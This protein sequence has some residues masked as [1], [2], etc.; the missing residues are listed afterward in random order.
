MKIKIEE[1][2]RPQTVV[3]IPISSEASTSSTAALVDNRLTFLR[4]PSVESRDHLRSISGRSLISWHL[5][6]LNSS[7]C[8]LGRWTI[9]QILSVSNL[10]LSRVCQFE[11]SPRRL[12]TRP[13][14]GAF[15]LNLWSEKVRILLGTKALSDLCDGLQPLRWPLG[16]VVETFIVLM[17]LNGVK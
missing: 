1:S 4:C 6:Q 15:D 2:T 16:E 3:V 13:T 11:R 14:E 7:R 17:A 5:S 9:N 10:R 8:S 12:L